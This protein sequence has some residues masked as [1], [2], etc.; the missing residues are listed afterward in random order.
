MSKNLGRKILVITFQN[1][2]GD[3]MPTLLKVNQLASWKIKCRLP[4]NFTKLVGVIGPLGDDISDSDLNEALALAGFGTATA[5]RILKGKNKVR[6]SMFKVTFNSGT[7]PTFL[8][9]GYQRFQ[10]NPYIAEPWQCF[11]CQGFGHSAISCKKAPRCVA[12]GGAH[13][14]KDCTNQGNPHCCN[15]GGQHTANYGGCPY[16]KEA[17]VVEKTRVEQKMSYRDA[18]RFV[19]Q[20]TNKPNQA[21]DAICPTAS[22]SQFTRSSFTSEKETW[23]QRIKPKHLSAPQT[24]TTGTQTHNPTPTLQDLTVT[25]FVE[26][27]S[28]IIAQCTKTENSDIPKIVSDLTKDTLQLKR[29]HPGPATVFADAIPAPSDAGV[30]CVPT[31]ES[32]QAG[33]HGTMDGTTNDAPI[34]PSPIIGKKLKKTAQ[35]TITPSSSQTTNKGKSNSKNTFYPPPSEKVKLDPLKKCLPTRK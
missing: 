18:L 24:V 2:P 26:L 21:N 16:M 3:K 28:K 19:K 15:C 1:E 33:A 4:I 12:C 35:I 31:L 9:L 7:L 13:N 34:G 11:K 8:I 25:Q 17:K 5:E 27:L 14:V 30:S 23:A 22:P 32:N 10:V 20:S 29:P 6:T